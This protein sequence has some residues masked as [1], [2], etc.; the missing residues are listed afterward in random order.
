MDD[1]DEEEAEERGSRKSSHIMRGI[2]CW[3]RRITGGKQ[4]QITRILGRTDAKQVWRRQGES[5]SGKQMWSRQGENKNG[6]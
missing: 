4:V 2:Y 5:E 3:T 1:D 6:K